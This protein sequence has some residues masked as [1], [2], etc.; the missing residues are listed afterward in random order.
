MFVFLS[1]LLFPRLSC[2][3]NKKPSFHS[4]KT[5]CYLY[6]LYL[7]GEEVLQE[8]QIVA[9]PGRAQ[10]A[11]SWLT[12]FSDQ[13]QRAGVPSRREARRSFLRG[14]PHFRPRAPLARQHRTPTKTGKSFHFGLSRPSASSSRV[15]AF[16]TFSPSRDPRLCEHYLNKHHRLDEEQLHL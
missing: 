3:P 1:C 4:S 10:E 6:S 16:P 9:P 15:P 13:Y 14:R 8:P 11:Y 12:T 5:Y 2:Y 7:D